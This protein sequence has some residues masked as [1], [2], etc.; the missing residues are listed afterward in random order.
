MSGD[1]LGAD[2]RTGAAYE[3]DRES[4]R[5]ALAADAAAR[6]VT[7]DGGLVLVFDSEATLRA[8]LEE[9]LRAERVTDPERVAGEAAAFAELVAGPGELVATLYIDDADP[10]GLADRV[11][12]LHGLGGAVALQVGDTTVPAH[13]EGAETGAGALRLRFA[14][15]ERQAAAVRDGRN[16][17]VVVDHPRIQ[18]RTR[19]SEEQARAVATC[20]R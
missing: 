13:E 18:A 14:L 1:A 2:V 12:E 15:D 11:A 6:R 3:S 19:L 5:E 17:A 10:A 7:I 20:L 16:L 8:A 9:F 4:A